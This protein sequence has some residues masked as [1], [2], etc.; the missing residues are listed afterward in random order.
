MRTKYIFVFAVIFFLFSGVLL[1]KVFFSRD[2]LGNQV[3]Q[4]PK[5]LPKEVTVLLTDNGFEPEVV[6]IEKGGAVRFTNNSSA[7]KASVNSDDYPD[8]KKFP[9]LNLGVFGKGSTLVHIFMAPGTFTYHNQFNPENT[10]T[11]V[12]R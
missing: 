4:T 2:T 8:N 12:V 3:A 1:G 10:G 11:I 5:S 9:E 6:E 7:E